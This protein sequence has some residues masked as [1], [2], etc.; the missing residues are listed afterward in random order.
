M[1]NFL[2]A[3]S[4]DANF[5]VG[6]ANAF[7]AIFGCLVK[8]GKM[9]FDD[10]IRVIQSIGLNQYDYQLDLL[11]TD[12]CIN[13]FNGK[14]IQTLGV[15]YHSIMSALGRPV[16]RE[17]VALPL[18]VLVGPSYLLMSLVAGISLPT[19]G[20]TVFGTQFLDTLSIGDLPTAISLIFYVFAL[21]FAFS[22]FRFIRRLVS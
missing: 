3:E 13:F 22:L 8:L 21:V 12:G 20:V 9:P 16:I 2:A 5:F 4:Y 14:E 6:L 15:L 18:L 11:L 19:S 17:L 1:F 7:G 10:F